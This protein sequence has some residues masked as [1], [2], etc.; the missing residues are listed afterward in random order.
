[1]KTVLVLALIALL[2]GCAQFGVAR[3]A[4]ALHGAQAADDARDTAE[5]TLCNG[6]TV[7]AWRRG[8]AGSPGK[9]AAWQ[10]LCAPAAAVPVDGGGK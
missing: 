3:Q 1:M 2:S 5:W 10:A 8:Y 6:I 7:G 4:V 9:A